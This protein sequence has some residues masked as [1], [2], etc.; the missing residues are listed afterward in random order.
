MGEMVTVQGDDKH[1]ID[2]MKRDDDEP[3]PT[4]STAK[5]V[6]LKS[7]PDNMGRSNDE[8]CNIDKNGMC[9]IHE[10]GT[11]SIKVTSKKWM[12]SKKT[13]LYGSR[14]VKVSKLIC[15]AKNGGLISPRKST[16]DRTRVGVSNVK[17]GTVEKIESSESSNNSHVYLNCTRFN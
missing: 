14:N 17:G 9:T 7:L 3:P 15:V 11:R 4:P 12:L 6:H 16:H 13:G 8:K 2:D 10:C 5:N 1:D